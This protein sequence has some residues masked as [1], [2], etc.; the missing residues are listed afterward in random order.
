ME[1]HGKFHPHLLWEWVVREYSSCG[2]EYY[3]S[4]YS[5]YKVNIFMGAN[6]VN[7]PYIWDQSQGIY[8]GHLDLHSLII[9]RAIP[10]E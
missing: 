1:M 10:E 6:W 7:F 5:S 9:Y 4:P 2:L 8:I 3:L